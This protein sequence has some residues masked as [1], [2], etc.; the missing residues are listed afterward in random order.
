MNVLQTEASASPTALV[1]TDQARTRVSAITVM[2]SQRTNT[3]VR[4]S[5]L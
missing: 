1:K 3:A 2:S 4:V 5:L